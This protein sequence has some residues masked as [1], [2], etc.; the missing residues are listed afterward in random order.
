MRIIFRVD[1]A[2]HIGTG[3]FQRCKTLAKELIRC[4]HSV[5]FFS[6]EFGDHLAYDMEEI[7]IP[8]YIIGHSSVDFLQSKEDRLW[9]GVS[10][11]EDAKDFIGYVKKFKIFPDVVIVDHY[12]LDSEW[13]M[14][15]RDTLN[16]KIVIIDD[17]ANRKH[18]CDILLDQNYYVEFERRYDNL[19]PKH[20]KL[21][22]GPS[23][24]LLREEFLKLR[25]KKNYQSSNKVLVNFGGIGNMNVWEK[26]IPALQ[27]TSNLY[28]YHVITGK[29]P[30]HQ[31]RQI[32][33]AL[34]GNNIVCEEVTNNMA[35]LMHESIFSIG[36]C[37]STVWER[38]C[39]GLNSCL[40]DLANNQIELVDALVQRGLIDYLGSLQNLSSEMIISY[41]RDL[42]VISDVYIDRQ[43]IIQELVDGMGGGRVVAEIESIVGEYV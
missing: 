15:I 25:V 29:L 42:S 28:S 37:G 18:Q 16:S 43:R 35:K 14:M 10:Q 8:V 38:F 34:L 36:A 27:K 26:F 31:Y 9:L 20:T 41:L 30:T 17:L 4:G 1:T 3:H 33:N 32:Y 5:C 24:I 13:E 11:E 21:L 23:Y 2:A 39:L 19:A 22:L 7:D 12:S 6:R 40:I